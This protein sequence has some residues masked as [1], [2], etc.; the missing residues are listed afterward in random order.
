M[1]V[2]GYIQAYA[3]GDSALIMTRNVQLVLER[4]R[5]WFCR[6]AKGNSG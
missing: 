2:K 6:R 4:F 5:A 3:D 1:Y